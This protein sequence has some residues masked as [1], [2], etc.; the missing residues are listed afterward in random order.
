MKMAATGAEKAFCVLEYTRT[1]SI[2]DVQRNFRSKF[3]KDLP[4]RRAPSSGVK[5]SSTN[6]GCVT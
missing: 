3:G 1:Q 2:V 4:V 5:N 6:F